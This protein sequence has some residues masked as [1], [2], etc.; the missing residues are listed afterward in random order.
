[1][2]EKLLQSHFLDWKI[3]VFSILLSEKKGAGVKKIRQCK[4]MGRTGETTARG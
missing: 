4:E 1:M 2:F 3:L